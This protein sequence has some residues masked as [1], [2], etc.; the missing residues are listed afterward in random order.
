[1]NESETLD[2]F[3]RALERGLRELAREADEGA[4]E[5]MLTVCGRGAWDARPMPPRANEDQAELPVVARRRSRR[6][7]K[8]TPPAKPKRA[9]RRARDAGEESPGPQSE[10]ARLVGDLLEAHGDMATL[11]RRFGFQPMH[12]G[13][14]LAGGAASP[15][16]VERLRQAL[17]EGPPGKRPP[18][19]EPDPSE[20]QNEAQQ[21]RAQTL[22]H[23]DGDFRQRARGARRA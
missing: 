21:E 7:A 4:A 15:A 12:L 17:A 11:S 3:A 19:S 18:E 5:W 1:M 6:R 9:R 8:P 16:V 14:V 2:L 20:G 23:G 22:L 13:R 10:A